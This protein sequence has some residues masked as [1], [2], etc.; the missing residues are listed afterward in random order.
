MQSMQSMQS[1]QAM[2]LHVQTALCLSRNQ[3]EMKKVCFPFRNKENKKN[4]DSMK[5][6]EKKEKR[7]RS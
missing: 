6:N 7:N 4:R 5:K 1:R 3:S 2:A